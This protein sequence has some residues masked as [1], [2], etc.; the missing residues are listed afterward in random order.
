MN[1]KKPKRVYKKTKTSQE[2]VKRE[3]NDFGEEVVTN[4]GSDERKTSTTDT[5]FKSIKDKTCYERLNRK[6]NR[7]FKLKAI[8]CV[9]KDCD[10]KCR[11]DANLASHMKS[12]DNPKTEAYRQ[13]RLSLHRRCYDL[14]TN[15]YIC[16]DISCGKSFKSYRRLR[17]HT[18]N[19]H[20]SRD[21]SCDYPDCHKMFKTSYVMKDHYKQFHTT[22]KPLKCPH[23]SCGQSY[24]NRSQLEAHVVRH[25]TDR[26]FVCDFIGCDI[27][28][29]SEACLK[30]HQRIHSSA[31]T[32]KCTVEG[33]SQRFQVYHHMNR[34]RVI[35][36]HFRR[37]KQLRKAV[38]DI[39]C[40]W[41]GCDYK[42]CDR[43]KLRLH[44]NIHTDERPYVCDWPECGKRFRRPT[45]LRDH[46][47]IHN[48]VKP[49]ACHWPGCQYRC[50]NSGNARKHFKLVHQK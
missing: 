24:L 5:D 18:I 44:Q 13:Q 42:V 38:K 29:K 32:I 41:P 40:Q 20:S 4:E 30:S 9:Y 47:N 50:C 34:H 39:T 8:Q 6:P 7:V 23:M 36:H 33:C 26:P 31:L 11:S 3:D 19:V 16:D 1:H 49:Y 45:A 22:D 48:N 46:K 43:W 37:R 12:H 28:F 10:Y 35:D 15:S 14:V 25:A 17:A 2:V 27:K 21:V